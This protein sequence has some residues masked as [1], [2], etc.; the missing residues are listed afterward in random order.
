MATLVQLKI[1]KKL[2]AIHKLL[3]CTDNIDNLSDSF[4]LD[5]ALSAKEQ[6]DPKHHVVFYENMQIQEG[7]S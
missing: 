7:C 6:F 5:T 4:N 3:W 2:Q 1:N